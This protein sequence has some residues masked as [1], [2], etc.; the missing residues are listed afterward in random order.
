VERKERED[1]VFSLEEMEETENLAEVVE[2]PMEMVENLFAKESGTAFKIFAGLVKGA[3]GAVLGTFQ[4]LALAIQFTFLRVPSEAIDGF[5]QGLEYL[6]EGIRNLL[7]DMVA[8]GGK[9]GDFARPFL[10]GM[11]AATNAIT[12]AR[13]TTVGWVVATREQTAALTDAFV[14]TSQAVFGGARPEAP[15]IGGG[16]REAPEIEGAKNT[17]DKLLSLIADYQDSKFSLIENEQERELALLTDDMKQKLALHQDDAEAR[18][19][20]SAAYANR[21]EKL[22]RESA[23]TEKQLNMETTGQIVG[24]FLQLADMFKESSAEMFALA[25]G[26]AVAQAAI[27]TAQA[28]TK[29][30]TAGP[31]LGPILAGSIAALGAAQ[32]G[33][34]LNTKF[35]AAAKG[36]DFET[37]GPELLLVGDNPGGRERVQVTPS[38]S[39]GA[40]RGMVI[41]ARITIN[42]NTDS[43]TV[44]ALRTGRADQLENIKGALRELQYQGQ[45][46]KVVL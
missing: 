17:N 46:T 25:K 6:M 16:E 39:G 7:F 33:V 27:N 10:S 29:A 24:N 20:I 41:D 30:L 13:A 19:W 3:V 1:Q 11:V 18:Y 26:L 21:R 34:I 32:V 5:L 43:T 22:L 15:A 40:G 4:A 35:K 31:I 12:K 28:I 42:G 9:L 44:A 14:K 8:S 37:S 38:G 2:L 45:I 23:K 36:A